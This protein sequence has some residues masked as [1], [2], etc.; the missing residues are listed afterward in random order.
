M[1]ASD[2]DGDGDDDADDGDGDEH[3]NQMLDGPI[4]ENVSQTLDMI[5]P[6]PKLLI[7]PISFCCRTQWKVTRQR[8]RS[9]R[10]ETHHLAWSSFVSVKME[11]AALQRIS[12]M[13]PFN[14]LLLQ[15]DIEEDPDIQ[16]RLDADHVCI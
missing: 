10:E 1:N 13:K 15:I 3:G 8:L 11:S 2:I 16:L 7:S 5:N 4:W 14:T 6:K 12:E 9:E